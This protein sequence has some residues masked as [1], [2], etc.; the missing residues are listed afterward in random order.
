MRI[1]QTE[2]GD[3]DLMIRIKEDDV[4]A[5][6][7]F[8]D[9][10]SAPAFSLAMRIL[11]DR[12]LAADATQEAFLAFWRHRPNYRP[13]QSAAK[14]W[15]LTIVR[16]RALDA[17]RRERNGRFDLHDDPSLRQRPAP[18][19]TEDQAIAG[20]E[21]QWIRVL[22]D[23]LPS[24]QRLVIELAYFAGLTHTEIARRLDLPLGTIKGRMRLALNKLRLVLNE[25]EPQK[26]LSATG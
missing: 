20:D 10:H 23:D 19:C 9:R 6:E 21:R 12:V 1:Q 3:V 4:Q 14:S 17:W 13:E 25:A 22:L 15:L 2:V 18:D 26:D 5:F 8:Y 11:N 24:E 16:H 7:A